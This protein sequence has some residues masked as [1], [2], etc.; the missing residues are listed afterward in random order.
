MNL[1]TRINDDMKTAMKARDAQTLS[2]IRLLMSAM[3]QKEVD[4]RV[5][6][7]DADIVS[8]IAKM[9]KQRSESIA[10]YTAGGRQDLVDAEQA[11]VAVLT[12]Y[13]P[14]ALTEQEIAGM[15]QTA[16]AQTGAAGMADMGKVM[17]VLRPELTGRAD[18][19]AV[20]AQI[21]MALT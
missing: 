21:K 12:A 11:E 7:S 1:K 4:E 2:A 8:I 14:Q 13:L 3:K 6:L 9:I 17:N 18:M 15:I 10:Q 20:S 16:I 19:A 5:E